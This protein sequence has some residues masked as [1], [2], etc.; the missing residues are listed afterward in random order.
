[1]LAA[2][3][4]NEVFV[5]GE[6]REGNVSPA[7]GHLPVY[8]RAK[9][10]VEVM[11]WKGSAMTIITMPNTWPVSMARSRSFER[12]AHGLEGAAYAFDRGGRRR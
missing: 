6:F 8:R 11:R 9:A 1:M 4:E 12:R 5:D 2:L 3:Y 7:V 10:L